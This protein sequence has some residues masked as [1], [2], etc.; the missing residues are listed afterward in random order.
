MSLWWAQVTVTPDESRIA[1][2]RRGIWKGL[3]ISI[4]T[5]GQIF[6]ISNV[7]ERL[8]WKKA[9]K[10]LKKKK[11]SEIINKIIPQRI[12]FVTE[13]VWIPCIVLSRLISR[14][15]WYIV[16]IVIINPVII[17]FNECKWNHFVNPAVRVKA[18]IAPVKGQGL[19]STRWKGWFIFNKFVV[20]KKIKLNN[21]SWI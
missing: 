12:P 10:N 17:K 8:L 1:V 18:P 19:K 16:K 21:F 5:G 4:F 20:I 14:H 15:H 6:P 13:I 2:L 3:K 11:N 9:Q 7:G